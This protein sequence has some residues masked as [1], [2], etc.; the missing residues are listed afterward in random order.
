[1]RLRPVLADVLADLKLAQTADQPR[2]QQNSHQQR[3]DAGHARTE[4][5]VLENPER[6]IEME[7]LLVTQPVQH[8]PFSMTPF[9]AS[10]LAGGSA[11]KF[12]EGLFDMNAAGALEEN[13]VAGLGERSRKTPRLRRIFE[14]KRGVGPKAGT[15]GCVQH[16][17]GR[18]AYPNEHIYSAFRHVVAY[19]AVKR[20]SPT[21]KLKHLPQNGDSP[22]SRRIAEHIQHGSHCIR[23]R[24]VTIVIHQNAP[25]MEA[26]STHFS[27]RYFFDARC[28]PIGRNSIYAGSRDAREN[29]RRLRRE[30][31]LRA[32]DR[33]EQRLLGGR[34]L[35]RAALQRRSRTARQ[36]PR[37]G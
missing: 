16:V 9:G 14:K 30:R 21:A 26:F 13:G 24:V 25:V 20:L 4:G 1:M 35:A 18:A 5:G 8:W 27:N 28:Q 32:I 6:R 22:V 12:L 2:P 10:P 31:R 29:V 34:A 3:G 37:A 19:V 15:L 36:K 33:R 23:V 17:T 11:Q 7:Q